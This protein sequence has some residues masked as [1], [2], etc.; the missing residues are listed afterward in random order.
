MRLDL[1]DM[2]VLL[3]GLCADAKFWTGNFWGPTQLI[4]KG[5]NVSGLAGPS[6]ALVAVDGS[7]LINANN[8]GNFSWFV[9]A[10]G[11]PALQATLQ[12]GTRNYLE[13]ELAT[14]NNTPLTRAFWDPSAQGGLGAEFNQTVDT[15]T[16][17]KIN[18]VV[19]QGG[20][21][22]STNRIKLAM[23]DTDGSNNITQIFDERDMFFRLGTPSDPLADYSWGTQKEPELT[24]TLT[25]VTGTFVAGETVTFNGSETA[26]V[27]TGGTTTIG[28]ILPSAKT[29]EPGD[30]VVS[31]SAN[32]T[33]SYATDQ[34]S[35]VDKSIDNLREMFQAFAT[36]IKAIKGTNFWFE[37][38]VGSISGINNFLSSRVVNN[39]SATNPRYEWSGT[40]LKVL[41]SVANP[42]DTDVMGYLR[43]WNRTNDLSM[44]RQD[45]GLEIQT[46]TF[47]AI[48]DSGTFTVDF[49]GNVSDPISF[50]DDAAA[51]QTAWDAQ[52]S[53]SVAIT[54]SFEDGFKIQF[55]SL[56]DKVAILENSN[57]LQKDAG[58]V[59]ITITETKKGQAT[60]NS[61]AIADQEV[62]FIKVPGTGNRTYDGVGSGDTN[63]QTVA[64]GSFINND[65]NYWLAYREGALLYLRNGATLAA[66][67]GSGI[68][69]GEVPASLLAI[70]GIASENTPPAYTSNVR[71]QQGQDFVSRMSANT[72][73][74]G[75]FQEDR[76]GYLRSDDVVTWTGTQLE[77]TQD[78]ILEILNTKSG[79]ITQHEIDVAGSPIV[80]A[81]GESL[82][83]KIDR[84]VASETL[85][86]NNSGTTPIPAQDQFDKDVFVLFRRVDAL[87][88]QRLHIPFHKQVLE[89]GQS[90]VLGA[91]GS[92]GGG[93][94]SLEEDIKRRLVLS[95]FT[96]ATANIFEVDKATKVDG[97]STGV[98]S[99]ADSAFEL[100]AAETMIS[101]QNLDPEFLGDELDV[102]SAEVYLK[103]LTG[104]IDTAA[105]YELSRD[106]GNEYQAVTMTRIGNTNAFRGIHTFDEESANQNLDT[107]DVSNADNTGVLTDTGNNQAR[108]QEF[109]PS[110]TRVWKEIDVYVNKLGSPLGTFKVKV[111]RDDTG[112]PS[113]SPADIVSESDPVSIS[114]LGSGNQTA[115]VSVPA[116]VLA[117]S[118]KYWWIVETDAAYKASF[119]SG[120]DELRLRVDASTPTIPNSV[121]W[122][123][124]VWATVSNNALTFL[125]KG[126]EHDLRLR[127]TGSTTALIEGYGVYYGFIP[128]VTTSS[129]KKRDTFFFTGDENRTDF[130]LSWTPDPD[131]M[132]AYDPLRGQTYV[133]A[134]GVFRVDGQTLKFEPDFF[135]FPGES[136]LLEVRENDASSY[137][138]S[139][140]NANAIAGI[141]SQLIDIG[142]E[143]ESISDSMILPKVAAPNSTVQN[144]S[145]MPDLSN[146]LRPRM[147][148]ERILAQESFIL[149]DETGPGGEP[150]YGILNDKFNQIRVIGEN[151][152]GND[153]NGPT[154]IVPL[155]SGGYVEFTFYGTGFNILSML[156]A[157]A[158]D[159]RVSIDGGPE[160][161]NIFPGASGSNVLIG[162]NY[163]ANQVIPVVKG[164]S[165]G[166]HTAKIRNNSASLWRISGFEALNESTELRL[167]AG[168]QLFKGKKRTLSAP[169]TTAYN[170]D[171]ESGTLGTRGGHVLVYQKSDGSIGKAVTPTE[172][173]QQNLGSANHSNEEIIR[174]FSHSEFGMGRTDDFSTLYTADARYFTLDDGT[175]TLVGSNV[176]QFGS[177]NVS[178][179]PAISGSFWA[180][181]FVG[182]GL[183]V[184]QYDSVSG[185][186]DTHDVYVDG[187]QVATGQTWTL[188]AG[189]KVRRKIVSGLPYGTHTVRVTRTAMATWGLAV[190]DFIIYGPKTPDLPTGAKEIADYFIMGDFTANTVAGQDRMSTGVLRKDSSREMQYSGSSWFVGVNPAVLVGGA[191]VESLSNTGTIK[192][193]FFGTGFDMRFTADATRSSNISVN[194]NSTAVTSANFPT[195]TIGVYGTGIT[196]DGQTG[197]NITAVT[198]ILD[199]NNGSAVSGCGFHVS[200][201]PL[202]LYEIEFVGNTNGLTIDTLDIITP[203]HTPKR[204]GPITIQKVNEIGS[205]SIGDLRRFSRKDVPK[206]SRQERVRGISGAT[207]QT[208]TAYRPVQDMVSTLHL[209][210]S[211]RVS[212]TFGSEWLRSTIGADGA[213]V[214]FLNGAIS[215]S[216][217]EA[218]PVAGYRNFTDKTIT[219][220]LPAGKHTFQLFGSQG[221]GANFTFLDNARWLYI[222]VMDEV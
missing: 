69:S 186:T 67:E 220:V 109:T 48:P 101:T 206:I 137:D 174:V 133:A 102:S 23:V 103:W 105:T 85:T 50:D 27:Q 203:I 204:N 198:N 214:L 147:G 123:G 98:F 66:G 37:T 153:T 160:G 47:S 194:L 140:Q 72:D 169:D 189:A 191:N 28:V 128:G 222:D 148:V 24:L 2:E 124:T 138:N 96:Y 43:L 20:F 127:V 145:L 136:I 70:L 190:S 91:S 26:T 68:S 179:H 176:E 188:S 45:D 195:S 139:D 111:V 56:G 115:N 108:G 63:Y 167:T 5:F 216:W 119:N 76:S 207:T 158:Q 44:T 51:F 165:L 12:P 71:G 14:E 104:N 171:F 126:R 25:G 209:E 135:D 18:V 159:A 42:G 166:L 218:N 6:P 84:E 95:P 3:S 89:P 90:V 99:P 83:V 193:T 81:D 38:G 163:S 97:A 134:E 29:F 187:I 125:A 78:I 156:E 74:I 192:Y 49:N 173:T 92:G 157:T 13:L 132:V 122:N 1:E 9:G 184:T 77:F 161:A 144:R 201:L 182:T 106:G 180:I 199:E 40:K 170:S 185:T 164:L 221:S 181:T 152:S 62:L 143:L 30:T 150:V 107:Y 8:T 32:G 141:L 93:G 162:R 52:I 17:I 64:L 217:Q 41:D 80:V 215:S 55:L 31:A 88:V 59:T 212:I 54:G 196:Y 39:P 21:S 175:T 117:N 73:A 33:L 4:V 142:D 53:E 65:E 36:E 205:E 219:I 16:N 19:L 172:A 154:G 129:K 46:L 34:F 211:S 146:D 208:V 210:K 197:G 177:N 22:G 121:E 120:V 82:W 87:G 10:A 200:G 213:M 131:L 11:D 113:T 60:D 155:N 149:E 183:D 57:T 58:G 79:T 61:I 7:V 86:V 130:L 151:I 118:T 35:G 15:V 112:K 114:A 75:D 168:S 178:L 94:A 100:D 110:T 116:M 202:A